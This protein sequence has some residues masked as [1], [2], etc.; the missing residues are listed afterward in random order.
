MGT[1]ICSN[2]PEPRL[3]PQGEALEGK[4]FWPQ[5][6]GDRKGGT[7]PLLP[8]PPASAGVRT[9]PAQ[10]RAPQ[11][12][13]GLLLCVL[14]HILSEGREALCPRKSFSPQKGPGVFNRLRSP[15]PGQPDVLGWG[16]RSPLLSGPQFRAGGGVLLWGRYPVCPCSV[17]APT[18][19]QAAPQMLRFKPPPQASPDQPHPAAGGP[20]APP[21][22]P[23]V[24]P[25]RPADPRVPRPAPAGARTQLPVPHGNSRRH[26]CLRC[27]WTAAL[28]VTPG[29]SMAAWRPQARQPPGQTRVRARAGCVL[30]P[31]GARG[32]QALPKPTAS[33]CLGLYRPGIRD[34][35]SGGDD[36]GFLF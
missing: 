22:P 4:C 17:P 30:V 8:D 36:L 5:R 29:F 31:A 25:V 12:G 26:K 7:K 18:P 10:D 13:L 32:T 21:H 35:D 15:T 14:E 3:V 28:R 2:L 16:S 33:R 1:Y 20:S 23:L 6:P 27:S 34:P 24:S 19:G 9:G 11:L